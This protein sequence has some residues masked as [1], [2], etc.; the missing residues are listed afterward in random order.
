MT[1]PATSKAKLGTLLVLSTY[2]IRQPRHGGQLRSAALMVEYKKTFSKVV[3]TAV[4]NS[5]VYSKREYSR[6]D[7]P[8]PAEL[9]QEIVNCPELEAWI[10]GKSPITS[11][12]VKSQLKK[13]LSQ[14]KPD[15]IVFEQAYM[16]LGMLPLLKELGINIPLIYSSHNVEA[17]MMYEIFKS[18]NNDSQH[19]KYLN[20]LEKFEKQ[21]V[22]NSIGT[23]AVSEADAEVFR[24]WGS[25]N[26]V[27]KGN[28]TSPY[29]ASKLK[30]LRIRRV[31]N[32]LGIRSYALFIA[33][34]HQPNIDG[35]ISTLGTRLGYIPEGSM[36]MLAG[37]IGRGLQSFLS[38]DHDE[39]NDLFWNRVFN[40]NRVSQKTLSALISE[41]NC[42]ILPITSGG[43]SNIKTAEALS[44]GKTIITT[45]PAMR[46]YENS[47]IRGSIHVANDPVDFKSFLVRALNKQ[48]LPNPN[49][50]KNDLLWERQLEGLDDWY[51]G[52]L[53]EK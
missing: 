45:A 18:N 20:E 34:S 46:G 7:I 28:G 37:D 32:K 21:L 17:Q 44:S 9:T 4:F 40:W 16:Y 52:L 24:H 35:F 47:E 23:V 25:R 39:W 14:T 30:R 10:L 19:A 13:L 53:G 42:I 29:R 41:A 6:T 43:G 11:S 50:L 38:K 49:Q 26:V 22:S 36:V 8:S 5:S 3:R 33:S 27:V 1:N 15:A 48:L 31:M 12:E 51:L 2:P